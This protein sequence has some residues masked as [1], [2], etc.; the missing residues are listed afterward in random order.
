VRRHSFLG[1]N[2]KIVKGG[3]G[4]KF[5]PKECTNGVGFTHFLRE[6]VPLRGQS[7]KKVC[8]ITT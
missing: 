8:E 1:D 7:H 6:N 4:S 3:G 2:Q 5:R